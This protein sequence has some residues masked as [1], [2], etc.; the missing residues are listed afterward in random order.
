MLHEKQR[1]K[2]LH[3]TYPEGMRTN[4]DSGMVMPMQK[5]LTKSLFINLL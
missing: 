4:G 3:E 2:R 1:A 5:Q